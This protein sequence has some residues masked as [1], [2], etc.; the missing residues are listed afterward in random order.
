MEFRLNEHAFLALSF[1]SLRIRLTIVCM[2]PSYRLRHRDSGAMLMQENHD[3]HKHWT[4]DL[5]ARGMSQIK[6]RREI[7]ENKFNRLMVLKL[8]S[9]GFGDHYCLAPVRRYLVI[10]INKCT[11]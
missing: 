4:L 1:A 9:C 8:F 10:G 11:P 2:A 5:A 7:V 3:A 6:M